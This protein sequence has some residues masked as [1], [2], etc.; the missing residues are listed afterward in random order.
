MAQT[1]K[2]ADP[3]FAALIARLARLM[4]AEY[5]ETWLRTP[6]PALSGERPLDLIDRGE[7][8]RVARLISGLE[9][10]TAT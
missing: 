9:G 8:R 4:K 2:E 5:V 6:I 7:R 3:E 10:T 1:P